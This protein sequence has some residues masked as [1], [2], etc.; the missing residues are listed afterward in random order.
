[1]TRRVAITGFSFRFPSTNISRYWQDLLDGRDLV[2]EVDAERWALET[3]R[4]PNK[5]HPGTSYTFAA[6]S[7]GDISKFDAGFFG[8][9]PREA[10]LMD[11]QQRLLLEMSWEAL[12][13]SGVMPSSIRGSQCGVFILNSA[14]KISQNL[15]KPYKSKH[16]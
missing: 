9:S 5:N 4:H 1:M 7:I 11:P 6:G 10:A 13:N 8:I 12:E 14:V 15:Y 3:F 2:T 16:G